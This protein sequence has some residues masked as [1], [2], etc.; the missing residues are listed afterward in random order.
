MWWT[1]LGERVLRG[2]E[3]KLFRDGFAMVCDMV[4]E[5][6]TYDDP[7]MCFVGIEAF[8]QLQPNQK[9]ALL[10]LVGKAL[11][12]QDEPMPA[13]TAHTEAAV[14]AVYAHVFAM[15]VMEIEYPAAS[16]K[17]VDGWDD[18]L[19][20]DPLEMD[21]PFSWRRRALAAYLE[22]DEQPEA[23]GNATGAGN[24]RV[25]ENSAEDEGAWTPPEVSSSDVDEWEFLVVELLANRILWDGDHES[26]SVYMDAAPETSRDLMNELGIA[27][28]YYTAVAPDPTDEELESV[29]R[30]LRDICGG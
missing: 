13:L 28:N 16:E 3:W 26:A 4:Q 12:D 30:T 6:K 15:I 27:E 29:R 7:E 23:A 9:L 11:K 21:D 1:P 8:D 17:K 25:A 10:A 20:D 19:D 24:D 5:S 18:P 2:A 22:D 14:A